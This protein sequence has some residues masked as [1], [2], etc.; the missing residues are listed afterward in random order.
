M[1]QEAQGQCAHTHT[2]KM[3]NIK[4]LI[5]PVHRKACLTKQA[6][7]SDKQGNKEMALMTSGDKRH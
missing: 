1:F 4:P 3:R 7:L 2:H 6:G 5:V